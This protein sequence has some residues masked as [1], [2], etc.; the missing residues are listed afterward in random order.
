MLSPRELVPREGAREHGG[1]Q[2][3]PRFAPR[4]SLEAMVTSCRT[5]SPARRWQVFGLAGAQ[6]FLLAVAS[7][8]TPV[9]MTAVVPAHRCGAAP[10]SHRVP[11]CSAS[12]EA[13]QQRGGSYI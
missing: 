4:P 5:G 11:F 1:G 10:E 3:P 8:I 6:S 9:R 13:N 12:V 2:H 7:Q